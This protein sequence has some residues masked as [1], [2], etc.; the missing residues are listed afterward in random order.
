M[1]KFIFLLMLPTLGQAQTVEEIQNCKRW[2]EISYTMMEIRQL[3]TSQTEV[4]ESL[5]YP[6]GFLKA[7]VTDAYDIPRFS[8]KSYQIRAAE[9]F[10]DQTESICLGEVE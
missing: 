2:G 3:G 9:D 10:R 4:L 8:S 6:D 7:I 5:E 1:K